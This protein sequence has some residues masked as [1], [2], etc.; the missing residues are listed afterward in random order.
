M[1]RFYALAIPAVL[2]LIVAA[3]ASEAGRIWF[4]AGAAILATCVA[5]SAV[6]QVRRR[7]RLDQP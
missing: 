1:T 3:V 4:L 2:L 5:F 6:R 7:G